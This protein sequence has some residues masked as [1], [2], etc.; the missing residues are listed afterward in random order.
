MGRPFCLYLLLVASQLLAQ[1]YSHDLTG[2]TKVV[3]TVETDVLLKTHTP[4]TLLLKEA[5]NSRRKRPAAAA[6]LTA[7][8]GRGKDNTGYGVQIQQAGGQLMVTGLRDRLA[9]GL[10][11]H[12]PADVKVS[13]Q[14]LVN[15]DISVTGFRSEIEAINH[16][17]EIILT[18]V[19][20][21]VVAE[22]N[23]GNITVVY[24]EVSQVSP[25]SFVTSG[26]DIDL[27]L[28]AA[29]AVTLK[30]KTPRG[31]FFTD[32]KVEQVQRKNARSYQRTVAGT[33]NGGGVVMDLRS[34]RGNIYLRK[35]K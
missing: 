19:T 34:V 21:P 3:I 10:T 27:Q 20:G 32:F 29:A 7:L 8:T 12:L 23:L 14:V 26:G 11:I 24:T 22:N 35:L 25:S 5:E 13:V 16:L 15:N 17:G 6:G 1:D 2:I 18:N 28:P 9:P 4:T 31:D 33:I 30:A